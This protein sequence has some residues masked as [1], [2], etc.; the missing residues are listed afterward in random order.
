MKKVSLKDVAKR[1]GVGVGTASRVLNK[2]EHVSEEKRNLVL[3]AIKDLNYQPDAIARSLKTNTTKNIGVILNNITNPFY[4]DLLRGLEI[5]A[6]KAGYSMLFVDMYIQK[7]EW[8]DVLNN[9]C[10]RKVDGIIYVGNCVTDE[11]AKVILDLPIPFVFT[12]T[13]VDVNTVDRQKIY[14]VD[15]NNEMAA[16]DVTKKLIEYGH[17]DI[18]IILGE[19]DDPYSTLYRFLGYMKA[20]DECGIALNE[21]WKH[22]GDFTFE[23][24]YEAMTK[25]LEGDSIPTAV[26]AISDLMAVGASKAILESGMRI[27][28][29]I[30]VFGFDGIDNSKYFHPE[31]STVFQPRFMMGRLAA[32]KIIGLMNGRTDIEVET[33][34]GY[35]IVMRESVKEI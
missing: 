26:F 22:Y 12:S 1:A 23:S 25:I 28:E 29:D 8:A 2:A 14:S 9:L 5:V 31:I 33:I 15:I 21:D 35:E 10:S 13:S 4:A 6:V 11:M 34:L 19:E 30:S 16:Y 3:Q 7:Y 27:P 24:G 20:L 32:E 18:G 17:K